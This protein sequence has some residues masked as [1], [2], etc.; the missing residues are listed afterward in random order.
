MFFLILRA[1]IHFPFKSSKTNKDSS[2]VT[3][4]LFFKFS[5]IWYLSVNFLSN[6]AKIAKLAV[7]QC[8]R[9]EFFVGTCHFDGMTDFYAEHL[10]GHRCLFSTED[11]PLKDQMIIQVV[12][13]WVWMAI[14][15]LKIVSVS[16]IVLSI[17]LV[18]PWL[19]TFMLQFRVIAA[20]FLCACNNHFS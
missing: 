11:W 1:Q 15:L 20:F 12:L 9:V 4:T 5:M 14:S 19:N 6:P 2:Y 16:L 3:K 13:S 17:W 7:I 8:L 18:L 10:H